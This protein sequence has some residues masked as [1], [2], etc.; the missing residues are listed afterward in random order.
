MACMS[1][2]H[3][4]RTLL[5]FT[6]CMILDDEVFERIINHLESSSPEHQGRHAISIVAHRVVHGG[7]QTD[8]MIIY[9]GHEEGLELLDKLSEFAPLH[10]RFIRSAHA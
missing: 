7:T 6:Y 4:H 8:P 9:K 10:V 1:C 5:T 3:Q 2:C